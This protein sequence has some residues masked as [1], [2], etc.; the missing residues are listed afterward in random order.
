MTTEEAPKSTRKPSRPGAMAHTTL[1]ILFVMN[2]LN[3]I[4]R[5]VLN[6]MLPLIKKEWS[7]SDTSLGLLVSAFAITY[8]FASPVFGWLGDRYVRKWIAGA[9]VA[10]WSVSTAAAALASNFGQLLGL[11]MILGVGEASYATTA[12]TIITDLYPRESRSKVLAF[13]Y[14]A[15]PVGYALGYILGGELGVRFGWRMAFLMVGLPGLLVALSIFFIKEP[16]RGQSEEVNAE[17]L[18][19]YLKT[20]LPL[21][22]YLELFRNKSYMY[23]TVAMILMTF[24][25]GGMAAWMPTFFYRVRGIEL[26]TA[27]TYFGVATLLAGIIGTFF[28]GWLADRLQRRYK[29][30]YFLV[31]GVG[32]L[33]SVPCGIVALYSENPA[34]YWP[35]IFWAEFFLFLNTGPAN[36]ILINVV[37]PKLRVGA[38]AINIF[39]IHALGDVLSPGIVGSV[40]DKTEDLR[41]ALVTVLPAAMVLSGV[42]YLVGMRHLEPDTQMVTQRMR[43]GQ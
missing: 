12:P 43:S 40:S 3:Y 26:K 30:A 41:F 18:S 17:E 2:L 33:L 4:D 25:T 11:R 31:S 34:V 21:K 27:S 16:V 23:D 28:G 42:F 19:E 38:F 5:S 36:A 9:G 8:M 37:M 10:V 13:F 7:L 29:S 39:L 35:A 15:I 24:A 32:M 20:S 6:G 22:A 14:V 1:A